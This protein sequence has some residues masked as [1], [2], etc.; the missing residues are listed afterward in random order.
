MASGGPSGVLLHRRRAR[1]ADA[2]EGRAQA[3]TLLA[4]RRSSPVLAPRQVLPRLHLSDLA[5]RGGGLHDVLV[6]CVWGAAGP[7]KDRSSRQAPHASSPTNA[8]CLRQAAATDRRRRPLCRGSSPEPCARSRPCP[9]PPGCWASR[10]ARCLQGMAGSSRQ[11]GPR[12]GGGRQ[13][14]AAAGRPPRTTGRHEA[15]HPPPK[16]RMRAGTAAR[17][18]DSLQPGEGRGREERDEGR[19]RGGTGSHQRQCARGSVAARQQAERGT[20]SAGRRKERQGA[21]PQLKHQPS[22]QFCR[23]GWAGRGGRHRWAT[24]LGGK[25]GHAA[26][27]DVLLQA[28]R[29][30]HACRLPAGLTRMP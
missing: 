17:P 16:V 27:A 15:A 12:M 7:E 11:A 18:R 29:L 1:C 26:A 9:A 13:R 14:Q 4:P 23:G 21:A 25:Q 3:C 22:S 6:L 5:G 19:T 30:R 20:R 10:A 8:R 28:R 24:G 2:L